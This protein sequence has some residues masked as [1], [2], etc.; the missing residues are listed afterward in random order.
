MNAHER[1]QLQIESQFCVEQGV[2]LIE[3]CRR[4]DPPCHGWIVCGD[5][6]TPDTGD[7]ATASL[8]SHLNDYGDYRLHPRLG[9]T[10]PSPLPRRA[11]DFVFMPPGCKLVSSGVVRSFLS[12]HRPVMVEF[13]VA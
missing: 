3:A 8:L 5:F 12:D 4:F 1:P 2:E 9:L 10:F 7:D 6:N 11:L 13:S